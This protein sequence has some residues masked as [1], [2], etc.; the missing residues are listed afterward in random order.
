MVWLP[1]HMTVPV[2]DGVVPG[3]DGLRAGA[4]VAVTVVGQPG[5]RAT[6]LLDCL[7]NSE[8]NMYVKNIN[9]II[10]KTVSGQREK[11]FIS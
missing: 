6:K 2:V 1:A 5:A 11:I 4:T 3:P 10:C 7:Q 9:Y 8:I